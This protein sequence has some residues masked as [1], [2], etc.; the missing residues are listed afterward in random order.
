[1]AIATWSLAKAKL[2]L[3]RTL[4]SD[5][6]LTSLRGGVGVAAGRRRYRALTVVLFLGF[7]ACTA[8]GALLLCHSYEVVVMADRLAVTLVV[9]PHLDVIQSQRAE[10][11]FR[12]LDVQ[13]NLLQQGLS[14][15]LE[16][17]SSS[18]SSVMQGTSPEPSS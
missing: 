9:Q 15:S 18:R 4:S 6:G 10:P 1:M 3:T 17:Y 13:C 11:T 5:N 12:R 7:L 8:A 2:S 14:L 16:L